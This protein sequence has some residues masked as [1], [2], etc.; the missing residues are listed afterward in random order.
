RRQPGRERIE[1]SGFVGAAA[2]GR[3]R[4]ALAMVAPRRRE[5]CRKSQTRLRRQRFESACAAVPRG[6]GFGARRGYGGGEPRGRVVARRDRGG[7]RARV[8]RAVSGGGG[9]PPVFQRL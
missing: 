8:A 4:A 2:R 5:R 1:R 9:Q 6:N 3:T 7:A